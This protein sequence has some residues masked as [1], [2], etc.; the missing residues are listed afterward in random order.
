L[1]GSEGF[2]EVQGGSVRFREVPG[3]LK[4]FERVWSLNRFFN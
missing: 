3:V 1:K 2:R 4:G